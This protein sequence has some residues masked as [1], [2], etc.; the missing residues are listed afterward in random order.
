MSQVALLDSD[1]T[2]INRSTVKVFYTFFISNI[3]YKQKLILTVRGRWSRKSY[4]Y[5]AFFKSQ[6]LG[7]WDYF[8]T[9]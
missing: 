3:L 4:P 8:S 9:E 6:I 7:K 2:E 5:K 1:I